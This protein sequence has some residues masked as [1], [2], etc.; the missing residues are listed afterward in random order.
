[1]QRY[2]AGLVVGLVA[3]LLLSLVAPDRAAGDVRVFIQGVE[4]DAGEA[5]PDGDIRLRPCSEDDGPDCRS[6]FIVEGEFPAGSPEYVIEGLEGKRA[7]VV[8]LDG[9]SVDQIFLTDAKITRLPD[10]S[11]ET[12][13]VRFF[14]EPLDLAPIPGDNYIYAVFA[15]GGFNRLAAG[16]RRAASFAIGD[17]IDVTGQANDTVIDRSLVHVVEAPDTAA[18]A[19]NT[20]ALLGCP[21]VQCQPRLDTTAVFTFTQPGDFMTLNGSVGTLGANIPGAGGQAAV[22]R[23]LKARPTPQTLANNADQPGSVLIFPKFSQGVV[24]VGGGVLEPRTSFDISVTCPQGSRCAD[25]QKVKLRARWVC[26]GEQTLP[27]KFICKS[28][29]FDL[30]TTVKGSISFNPDGVGTIVLPPG[31]P[32]IPKPPCQNRRGYLMV[33]VVSPDD[34]TNARAIK[35]DGLIGSAVLRESGRAASAYRAVAIQAVSS[36]ATGDFTDVNGD[37]RLQFDGV[38]EYKAIHGQV[39]AAVRYGTTTPQGN[40]SRID[41]FLA[42][43]TLDVITNRPNYPTFVDMNFYNEVEVLRSTATEFVCWALVRLDRDINGN[44]KEPF[45]RKGLFEAVTAEKIAIF[46]VDDVA[47]PVPL[48]GLVSTIE[49]GPNGAPLAAYTYEMFGD[50]PTVPAIIEPH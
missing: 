17:M 13:E 41:T 1:M 46:G 23:A 25:G 30:F 35:F 14:T 10:S 40:R 2:G 49:S 15:D 39:R 20:S 18:F 11:S 36:L 38:T 29:D 32:P 16:R 37:G 45:G 22:D 27:D 44:L 5:L 33:W 47:G 28:L 6:V 34:T 9:N 48:I 43:L 7:R 26:E 42:L 24:N 50:G 19:Q 12:L 3:T 31:H 4:L 21:G 8:L